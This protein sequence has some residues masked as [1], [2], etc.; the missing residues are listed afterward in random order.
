MET[1]DKRISEIKEIEAGFLTIFS[2]L[3]AQH[4][5]KESDYYKNEF[6]RLENEWLGNFFY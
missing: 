6:Y 5:G 2:T 3:L 4:T 1:I